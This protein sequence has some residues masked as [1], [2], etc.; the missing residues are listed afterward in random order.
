MPQTAVTEPSAPD[1]AG[2]GPAV[3]AMLGAAGI[4]PTSD[5]RE[6][7]IEMYAMYRPGIEALYAIPEVR[8]EAPA[9]VFHA[10][11]KLAEWG[12]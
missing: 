4:A 6:R 9:L 1:P 8:Y 11:P 12:K 10:D 2:Y 5:E 3:D 7:L